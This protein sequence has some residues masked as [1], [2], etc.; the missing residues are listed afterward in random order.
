MTKSLQQPTQL[1]TTIYVF[2]MLCLF[3]CGKSEMDDGSK[4]EDNRFTQ[5]V[6]TEGMDEPMEMTFLPGRK[7]L[8]VERKG[9]VKV[10]DENS[11]ELIQVGFVPVNTKYTN[12]EGVVREAEEGLM[13]VIADPN[14]EKNHWIYM[15]YADPDVP[16]H[17]LARWELKGNELIDASKK[18]L[19]EVPTQR[20]E[21]CHTGGGMVFDKDGNL[22][23]TTGNNTVN[24][25]EGTSNLD[26]RPGH[27]NSDD[28]R[29]PSNTNDLRGK[30]LRIKPEPDGTYSI[31]KGNLF[32]VG[33]EKTRPEIYTMGHRNPWRPTLDSKTGY[34]YWGEVGPDA[35]TD[36]I[37]GPKGYDEFNQAK[38]PGFFGWP[39]FIGDNQAY[40]SHDYESNTYGEPYDVN[41]PVNESVNNTGLRELPTPVIPAMIWYPYGVSEEFPML[42]SS[43]RSAT[44]GPVFRKADFKKDAPHVFPAYY[45][46]KWLIV[47]FMR[48]WI[49]AVTMDDNGDYVS[50]ERFLPNETFSSAID[51]DFGPDGALYI[52]EYGSAWFRGNPNSRIVKIEYNGGNRKP[53]VQATSD[54]KA[55]AVPFKA[56][57]SSEGTLDYDTYDQGKLKYEWKI[58]SDKGVQKLLK[59]KNPS[60]DFQEAGTYQVTLTVT[61]TKGEQNSAGFQIFAGNEPPQVKIE[62]S[63]NRTFYFGQPE[64]QYSVSVSDKEDGSTQEGKIKAE[65][66]AITFDYVPSGFDPIEIA[67]KQSGAETM[68][69]LNIGKNLIEGSDCKSCHQFDKTSIG[70]SYAAVA[71]KYPKTARNIDYLVDKILNGGSGVW[72]DHGMSAHPE[73]SES[74]AKRMV[75]FILSMNEVKPTVMPLPL[76]GSIKPEIPEG[77]DGQGGFLLRASYM[78][79]GA[80]Q[81]AS[82]S[83][84]DYVAL[85]NP[86]VDPQSAAIRKGVNLLT[87]PSINFFMV[88]DQSHVGFKSIDLSGV[89]A[90]NLFVNVSPRNGAVGG[91]IEARLGSP[92]GQIIGQSQKMEPLNQGFRRPPAGV[93]IIQWRRENTPKAEI[94]INNT[95]GLQDVFFIFRNPDAGKEDILMSI[96]EIQFSNKIYQD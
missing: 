59:E 22:Y 74:D 67:S 82:L 80:S 90:I 31:P 45:E 7:I 20:E 61:D 70:P 94:K 29:A 38:G 81:I 3:S 78:D 79:K 10:F 40:T 47:D 33:T 93:N 58:V 8:F 21:C 66:V 15:Y 96:S 89:E 34:L 86:F 55:G 62:F 56:N 75:D 26:E 53:M 2:L 9:A 91:Y 30:I 87:T 23:L 49:M 18:I 24:P 36:S 42:G 27:E 28:Q 52:L 65:E 32:P 5:V 92:D 4:P 48:G 35:V 19:L 60:F 51:M 69:V 85:K 64:I 14:Y 63:G 12:K 11:G 41:N 39:Y 1:L 88:G 6:L 16:K 72:G 46:G 68:A 71:E 44:G 13:G 43:G 50:M 73:L 77:E 76:S 37:W 95:S 84:V 54:K 57:L 83:G 17:V 25:R